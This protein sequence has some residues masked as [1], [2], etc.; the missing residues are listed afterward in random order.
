M[1]L[2]HQTRHFRAILAILVAILG[3]CA[4]PSPFSALSPALADAF[5]EAAAF[6]DGEWRG[7]GLTL[8]V[9]AARAQA[10]IDAAR[11]FHWQRFQV[12]AVGEERL[13]FSIG[14]E[15]YEARSDGEALVLTGTSFRGEKR[16]ERAD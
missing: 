3:L 7:E 5:S 13:S 9:D 16:L 10:N 4:A 6:L 12:K 2:A 14:A 15:L 8:R 1:R 11:P